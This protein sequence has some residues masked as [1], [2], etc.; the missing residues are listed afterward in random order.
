MKKIEDLENDI[1]L[2]I[3]S[4]AAAMPA[5]LAAYVGVLEI[6]KNRLI[7]AAVAPEIYQEVRDVD[8]SEHDPERK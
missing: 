4:Y 7:A 3:K 8:H 5:P 6:V 2:L 1:V